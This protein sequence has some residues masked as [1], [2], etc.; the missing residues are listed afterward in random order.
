MQMSMSERE[1]VMV[2]LFAYL[3]GKGLSTF[4]SLKYVEVTVLEI[5]YFSSLSCNIYFY[6]TLCNLYI[7]I[8]SLLYYEM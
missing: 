7:F 2:E 4:S 3:Y 8:L 5:Q 6:F 1:R